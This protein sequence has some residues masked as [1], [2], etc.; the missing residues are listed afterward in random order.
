MYQKPK[1]FIRSSGRTTKNFIEDGEVVKARELAEVLN[2]PVALREASSSA[3]N[4][5]RV[6]SAEPDDIMNSEMLYILD[7]SIVRKEYTITK[8]EH[9]WDLICKDIYGSTDY[10]WVL[11]HV[12]KCSMRELIRG[13]VLQYIPLDTLTNLLAKI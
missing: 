7:Q 6:F 8:F 9:R 11:Q 3:T 13:K 2:D 1:S 5:S 10:V 12:N 4:S